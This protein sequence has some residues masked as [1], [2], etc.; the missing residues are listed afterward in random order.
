MQNI[1]YRR[2]S[3]GNVIVHHVNPAGESLK[4]DDIEN[5]YLYV[6]VLI[7]SMTVL[8]SIKNKKKKI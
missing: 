4:D 2:K 5:T 8:A 7:L 1:N 6:I 3:A